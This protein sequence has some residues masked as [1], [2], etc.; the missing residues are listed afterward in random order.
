MWFPLVLLLIACKLSIMSAAIVEQNFGK[1]N[2]TEN[3]SDGFFC[4][5]VRFPTPFQNGRTIRAFSSLSHEDHPGN[6]NE[7]LVAVINSV[8]RNSFSVCLMEPARPTGEMTLNWFAFSDG[9]LPRGTL[10]GTVSYGAFTSGSVCTDVFFSR[11]FN[12]PPKI[13]LSVRHVG[14]TE[15]KDMMTS[16]AEDV[17]ETQ[18]RVCLREVISFSGTHENLHID[19]VAMENTFSRNMEDLDSHLSKIIESFDFILSS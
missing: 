12:V 11:V 18:L 17:T 16:W 15:R 10:T 2:I 6:E 14:N 7:A 5:T 8:D 4:E 13:L 3:S 19:W 1:A 9:F